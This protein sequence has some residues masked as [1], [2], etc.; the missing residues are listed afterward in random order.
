MRGCGPRRGARPTYKD[1][2]KVLEVRERTTDDV[3]KRDYKAH[4]RRKEE[5]RLP[6]LAVWAQV[7]QRI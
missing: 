7:K 3:S 6:L 5:G 2:C 1:V 4:Q